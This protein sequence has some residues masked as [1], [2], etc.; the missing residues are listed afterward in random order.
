MHHWAWQA[1]QPGTAEKMRTRQIACGKS[2]DFLGFQK[3]VWKGEE[4]RDRENARST[5]PGYINHRVSDCQRTWSRYG[6]F[7]FSMVLGRRER[8]EMRGRVVGGIASPASLQIAGWRRRLASCARMLRGTCASLDLDALSLPPSASRG[9]LAT[10]RC[11]P[12]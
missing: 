4:G 9:L 11:S 8:P 10:I 1:R 7:Q 3:P 12:A 2:V 6:D 5:R